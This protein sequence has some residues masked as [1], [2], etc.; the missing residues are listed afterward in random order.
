VTFLE[1]SHVRALNVPTEFIQRSVAR[2]Q[3]ELRRRERLFREDRPPV[4]VAGKTVILV[5]DGLATGA[6]VRAAIRSLRA[7][8]PGRIVLAVPIGAPDTVE[9]LRPEVDELVCPELPAFFRAVGQGYVDFSPT[10]DEEVQLILRG[11][12]IE[13]AEGDVQLTRPGRG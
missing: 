2:E 11:R 9:A 5:D 7:R 8:S 4:E 12:H 3:E 1:P 13:S 10:S 6:T